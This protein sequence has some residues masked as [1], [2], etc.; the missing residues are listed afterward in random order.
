[1][2]E[3]NGLLI[4]SR[5]LASLMLLIGLVRVGERVVEELHDVGFRLNVRRSVG[6][7][8]QV[9]WRLLAEDAERLARS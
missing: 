4:G 8:T 5:M 3:P 1:M 7:T 2:L 6:T 9:N